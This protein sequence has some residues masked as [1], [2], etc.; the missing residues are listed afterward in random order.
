MGAAV[1]VP[2]FWLRW[3]EV[4]LVLV[5]AYALVLVFTGTVAQGL[6]SALGFGPPESIASPGLSD[7]LRLPFAVL[8]AVL[9]AFA[10]L[11]LI[12]VRGPLRTGERWVITA[13][14]FP[15]GL[16]F[17]LDTVMSLVLGFPT[18]A[19]FNLVFA[20]S[21]AVPLWRLRAAFAAGGSAR[22][23]GT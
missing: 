4:V 21:L 1:G 17:T 6:F 14:A 19:L 5:L 2:A 8:G 16:W 3:L 10:L 11:M 23:V 12:L 15:L 9:A 22:A 18:H 13:I 7:Y 20:A